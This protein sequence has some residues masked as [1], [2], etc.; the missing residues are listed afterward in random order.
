MKWFFGN[1]QVDGNA[2]ICGDAKATTRVFTTTCI[3][4]NI[5]VTDTHCAIGGL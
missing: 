4:H 3:N 2:R 5:T 1:A